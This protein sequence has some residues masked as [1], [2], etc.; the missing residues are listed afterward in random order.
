[1]SCH[2][3]HF[4]GR[5]SNVFARPAGWV[6]ASMLDV[7]RQFW[8]DSYDNIRFPFGS[9]QQSDTLVLLHDAFMSLSY[10][11][12]FQTPPAWQG[13]AMDTHIYQMFSQ[14]V[15]F[16]FSFRDYCSPLHPDNFRKSPS[17]TRSISRLR[18]TIRRIFR[19]SICGLSLANGVWHSLIAPVI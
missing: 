8:L 1:M 11:S 14:K 13:V 6:G 10:W 17:R 19:P 9:T 15:W 3:Y 7:V 18:V 5:L 16:P 4:P 12:G 2:F